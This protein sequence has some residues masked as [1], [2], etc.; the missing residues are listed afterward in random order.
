MAE[1][2]ATVEI[3]ASVDALWTLLADFGDI[4][5]M[6]GVEKCE[7]SGEGIGMQRAVYAMGATDPINEVLESLDPEARRLGYGIPENNPLPAK[8]YHAYCEATDLGDGRSQLVWGCTF[9]PVGGDEAA[10]KAMVEGM[11]G[12]LTGWVKTAL[13]SR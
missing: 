2:K 10:A 8:D 7:V 5:W 12:V 13:E 11:Y 4:S 3:E 1:V 9:E 6:Q